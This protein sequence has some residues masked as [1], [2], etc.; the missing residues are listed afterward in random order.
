MK[1]MKN[2]QVHSKELSDFTFTNSKRFEYF[3][4]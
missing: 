4:F 1:Q 3:I 2:I